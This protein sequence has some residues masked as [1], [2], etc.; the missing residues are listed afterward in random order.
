M[1]IVCDICKTEYNIDNAPV[2]AVRCAVCGHVWHV[3]RQN[4][5]SVWLVFFA[6]LCALLSAIVFTVAVIARQHVV[7]VQTH[8]LVADVD[9]VETVAD[10]GIARLVVNGAVQN[11]SDQIYGMPDL[12]LVAWGAD[13]KPIARQK[14]MPSATLIEGGTSVPFSHMLNM[15]PDG[16]K[17]ITA[18]L[19]VAEDEK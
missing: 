18:E 3:P 2:A 4:R 5:R 16:I 6:S 8:P 10:N 17:K 1:K 12:I 15:A 14:F 19:V 11:R 7:D 13:N 9:S